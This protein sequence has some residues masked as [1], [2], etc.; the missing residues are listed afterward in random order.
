VS[1]VNPYHFVTISRAKDLR[2][3]LNQWWNAILLLTLFSE[4]L[5][6]L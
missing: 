2:E 4:F 1:R 3:H 5:T 6:K